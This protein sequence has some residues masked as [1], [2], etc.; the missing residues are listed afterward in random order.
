LPQ[1][2]T[3]MMKKV[4][5]GIVAALLLVS[6]IGY[7][8]V[9]SVF[10]H[11]TVRL[12]LAS[13]LSSAIGQ[14]VTIESIG[15]AIYPRVTVR[16][17][18]V[19]I[20]QPARIH[21]RLLRLG[22]DFRALLSRQIVGGTVHLD[23]ARLELPLPPLGASPTSATAAS[24]S[25]SPLEIVSVG[26][27]VLNDVEI[28]SSGRT[29]HG[30]ILAA[31]HGS[32]VTLSKIS[33]SAE[34]TRLTGSGE[35]R[36][37]VGP[38]GEVTIRAEALNFTRL[39]DFLSAF[40]AGSGMT[41]TTGSNRAANAPSPDL[42]LS[43]SADR[44]TMGQMALDALSGRARVTGQGVTFD[45]IEFGV[46]GG[47]YKG[48]MA[49]TAD[50]ATTFRL[51]ADVSNIDVAAMTAFAGSP[52]VIS[53]RLSG[54][55]EVAGHSPDPAG[56]MKSARGT[57]RVDIQNGVVKRLGL[58]KT[59]VIATSMRA[60][61]KMPSADA[62]SDEPFSQL[63]A[64]MALANGTAHTSDLRFESPS[65]HMRSAGSLRLDGNAID[66]RGDVQLSDALSQQAGRDLYRYTQQQ[67][68]VTL[69]VTVRGS[70]QAPSVQVD[71]AGL[72]GRA[73]RNKA[74]EELRKRLEGLF[75]RKGSNRS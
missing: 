71:V 56:A 11:D 14:P 7:F 44:A 32:G 43:L 62:S 4:A 60:D 74:E 65:V 49:V 2:D 21:V 12:A 26:E 10:V 27:I 8:W 15:A 3:I 29:L 33:L 20:G 38:V 28:V 5:I 1:Q 46:F 35:I 68:R 75:R 54:R 52:G 40:A 37:L 59:I 31:P 55:L 66:L 9:R 61:A 41:S 70:A 63:G 19:S 34:D 18:G 72:A 17:G 57:A 51:R 6:V 23:G 24:D 50:A 64:T 30:D 16:L 25:K 45:P 67:G 36:N 58:V 39:I 13:Q 53:G 73:L 42:T 48:T 47:R 22:T 69:P